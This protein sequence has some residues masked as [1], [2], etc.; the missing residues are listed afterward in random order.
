MN[1]GVALDA[2]TLVHVPDDPTL[3]Q[4]ARSRLSPLVLWWFT[5]R[6]SMPPAEMNGFAPPGLIA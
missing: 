6:T 1:S 4:F 5:C 3:P 2:A